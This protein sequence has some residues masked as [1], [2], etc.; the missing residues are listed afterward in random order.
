LAQ[1]AAASQGVIR[2]APHPC[3]GT[4]RYPANAVR[5]REGSKPKG[6]DGIAG[7]GRSPES[8]TA[9]SAPSGTN[10][11]DKCP[12]CHRQLPPARVVEEEPARRCAPVIQHS[13]QPACGQVFAYH[14]LV[15]VGN[16]RIVERGP[17]HQR[18]V[19]EHQRSRDFDVQRP[20]VGLKLP[21]IAIAARKAPADAGMAEQFAWCGGTP[22]A[23]R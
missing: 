14:R 9:R 8:L 18:I 5:R 11:I 1:P 12:K 15:D 6:R 19:V 13:D 3:D 20:A 2:H 22:C 21:G 23:T 16:A 17:D 10:K 7:T 4:L